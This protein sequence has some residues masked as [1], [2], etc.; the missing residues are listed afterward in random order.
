MSSLRGR[1]LCQYEAR[2]VGKVSEKKHIPFTLTRDAVFSKRQLT[3][4]S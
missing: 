4:R 2:W 1:R 3:R